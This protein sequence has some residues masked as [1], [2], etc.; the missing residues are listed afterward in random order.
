MP[1]M[2]GFNDMYKLMQRQSDSLSDVRGTLSELQ[3]AVRDAK[4]TVATSKD[5]VNSAQRSTARIEAAIDDLEEPVR[6][7]RVSIDKINSVVSHPAVERI[8][9]TV[10]LV[11]DAVVPVAEAVQ[12]FNRRCS[13]LAEVMRRGRQNVLDFR[14]RALRLRDDSPARGIVDT[15]SS[16][17]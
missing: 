2:S 12:R 16:R 17:T 5:T 8:P 13:R 15:N 7:L 3:Q 10:Q 14:D 6:A 11:E 1:G 4:E 9:D